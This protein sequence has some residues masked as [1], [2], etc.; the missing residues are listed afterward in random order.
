MLHEASPYH[1]A[2]SIRAPVLLVHGGRDTTAPVEESQRMAERLQAAGKTA[3]LLVI[4]EG[5]HIFNFRDRSQAGEA[6]DATTAWLDR[7]LR[8]DRGTLE[9]RVGGA[10]APRGGAL[11]SAHDL[12]RCA[13]QADP[14]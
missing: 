4:P 11:R 1:V 14:P 6:W 12:E 8:P 7:Y 2:E 5:K 3:S 9:V 10:A 13:V